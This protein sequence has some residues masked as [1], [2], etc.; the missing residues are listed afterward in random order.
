VRLRSFRV[1]DLETLYEI[2]SACFPPGVAY[3][4]EELAR[5]IGHRDSKTWVAEEKEEILGFMVANRT[6]NRMMHIITIDVMEHSRRRRVGASL[7]DAAEDWASRQ[8]LR[9]VTLETAEENRGAQEFYRK[10]GYVKVEQIRNYYGDG[11]TAWVMGKQ[12]R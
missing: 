1:A 12:L 4:K 3:S 2:D 11:A 8:G 7:M 10:R 6:R 5:F 9:G